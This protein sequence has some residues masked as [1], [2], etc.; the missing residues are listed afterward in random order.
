MSISSPIPYGPI[1]PSELSYSLPLSSCLAFA[2]SASFSSVSV[3]QKVPTSARRA[4]KRAK[5]G[6]ILVQ[7]LLA[8]RVA[9]IVRRLMDKECPHPFKW[10]TGYMV[11]LAGSLIVMVVSISLS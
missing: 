11:M 6:H 3:F 2:S 10:V 4:L 5:C 9:V 7:S 8:G 1:R